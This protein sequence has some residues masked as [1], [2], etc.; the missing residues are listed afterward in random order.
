MSFFSILWTPAVDPRC[1]PML[2]TPAVDPRSVPWGRV[3]MSPMSVLDVETCLF[4][5]LGFPLQT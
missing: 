1:G 4:F 2:W 5:Y 3:A